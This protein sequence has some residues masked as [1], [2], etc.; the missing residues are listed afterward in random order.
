MI[1]Y[2]DRAAKVECST[3]EKATPAS[4]AS[5]KSSLKDSVAELFDPDEVSLTLMQSAVGNAS[6][7]A[8]SSQAVAVS[9]KGGAG[10]SAKGK[11]SGKGTHLDKI[12][13]KVTSCVTAASKVRRATFRDFNAIEAKSIKAKDVGKEFITK[14]FFGGFPG[15]V[16]D[17]PEEERA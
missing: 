4:V 1:Q 7:A 8:G 15:N 11:G 6:I 12:L 13:N 10:A 17:I 5:M 9:A 14:H 2:R 3:K 16:D